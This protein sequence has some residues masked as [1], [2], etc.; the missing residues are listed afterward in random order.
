MDKPRLPPDLVETVKR[1]LVE[2][3]GSGDI[4]A[5]LIGADTRAHA[6]VISREQ[7]ILCGTA[8]FD[9][10]FK[11]LDSQVQI[12]WH[13]LDGE[14]ISPNQVLCNLTGPARALVTGERT[15][16]NF[17]QLLSGTATNVQRYVKAISGT[18]ACILDTRKTLPG[19][20]SAQKYAVRCGGGTNHRL[21]LYDAFLIKENHILA[22]GSITQAIAA[23]R[24]HA[25]QL[26][27]EVEVET[28]EQ[29]KEALTAG[30]DS[31]LLDNFAV[32][33]LREAVALVQSQVKLEA[34]GGVTLE[35]I[36][37]IAETEVDFI[38]V[39][40]MTKDVQAVDLSMRITEAS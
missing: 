15:A 37:A 33:Q 22:A 14:P 17:L 19:L 9:E 28:L 23:A 1:A 2:D 5:L 35:T 13:T 7:A 26:P 31:L 32:P 16:L 27:V 20:R 30:A 34:S 40:A 25:A 21:G 24:H 38:S 4:T 8:W 6:Q 12:T 11:Q 36:R 29:V 18:R 39:G 3:V 10:V